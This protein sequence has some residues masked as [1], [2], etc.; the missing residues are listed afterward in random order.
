MADLSKEA[1]ERYRIRAMLKG[2][3]GSAPFNRKLVLQGF[4][5]QM[6]RKLVPTGFGLLLFGRE[7]RDVLQQAGLKG[8]IEYPDGE[9]EIQDFAGPMI[10]MPNAVEGWLRNKLP[11]VIDRS[12][13]IRGEKD[14][15][16]FDSV[17]E[18][19]I[20]ALVHRDYDIAGATC[21][22]VV[23]ADTITVKSPGMPPPPVTLEQLQAFNAPMLNRNPK[24]QFV[25]GGT[26]LVEGRG[27][28]MR[29]LGAMAEKHRLPLPK[30]SFD[31]VYLQ[32]TIYR[33]AKAAVHGLD[34]KALKALSKSERAG[35]EW[36]SLRKETTS[37][38]YAEAMKLPYR[39]AMNHLRSFQELGLLER[40][41]SARA[42]EYR[43][44][45][46]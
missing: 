17:R 36:L 46:P 22:L 14:A 42:T 38:D 37:T 24:L 6:G 10:L 45:R 30:Y 21:H 33:H 2:Q 15:L 44:L 31:G 39:T 11:N 19:I 20:N 29:T 28:G 3:A 34:A 16:P 8:M 43:I 5:C 18:A 4:L 35:W 13:M 1:L 26:K 40:I 12:R 9:H 7:P 27:L 41:G 23:T 32:L 25:F